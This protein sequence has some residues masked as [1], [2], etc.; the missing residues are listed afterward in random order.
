MK[1]LKVS[2][3]IQK[4]FAYL[5]VKLDNGR[6]IWFKS[7]YVLQDLLPYIDFTG[8]ESQNVYYK[9]DNI[10]DCYKEAKKSYFK[11]FKE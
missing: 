4:E 8:C 6:Y 3:Y 11:L 2:V 1:T 9:S 5:P 10:K 7:Y